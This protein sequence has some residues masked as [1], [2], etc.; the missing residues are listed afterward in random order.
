[1][2]TKDKVHDPSALAERLRRVFARRRGV[3]EKAMFGGVCFLDRGNMLCGTAKQGFMFRIGKD[4][5]AAALARPGA[6]PMDFTGR[7]MAGFVWVDPAACDANALR[8]WIALA[9]GYVTALPAR[10]K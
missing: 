4:Q 2:S 5:H 1:M 7:P 10:S 8:R 3:T 9:E 6:R